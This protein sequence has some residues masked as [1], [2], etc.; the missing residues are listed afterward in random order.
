MVHVA[1][2]AP[3]AI[4]IGVNRAECGADDGV[5]LLENGDYDL[6]FCPLLVLEPAAPPNPL[7]A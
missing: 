5:P 3:G 7:R 1:R 2:M 4:V 6:L